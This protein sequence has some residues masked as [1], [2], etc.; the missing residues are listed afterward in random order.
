MVFLAPLVLLMAVGEGWGT[1]FLELPVEAVTLMSDGVVRAR[2]IEVGSPA[3]TMRILEVY[4]GPFTAGADLSLEQPAP[5]PTGFHP[6]ELGYADLQPGEEA[7]V[8]VQRT[9]D[10]GWCV[11]AGFQGKFEVVVDPGGRR[12]VESRAKGA[13]IYASDTPDRAPARRPLS[14]FLADLREFLSW[15]QRPIRWAE[16]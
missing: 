3:T 16:Q 15:K 11:T 5:D 10:G 4:D 6:T 2:V 14:V 7:I 1:T 12:F 13:V 8:F 9:A